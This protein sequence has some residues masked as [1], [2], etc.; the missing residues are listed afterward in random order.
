MSSNM[1]S[2]RVTRPLTA[3]PCDE[4]RASSAQRCRPCRPRAARGSPAP[5]PTS[6][7]NVTCQMKVSGGHHAA[8]PSARP[9]QDGQL[10][11]S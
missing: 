7:S 2:C 9:R 1:S 8:S 6:S 10:S 3:D 11:R 5:L 4:E